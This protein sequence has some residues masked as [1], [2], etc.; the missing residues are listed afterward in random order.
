ML[1]S[2]VKLCENNLDIILAVFNAL[3]V[4]REN[5]GYGAVECK[6]KDGVVLV[7]KAVEEWH[8]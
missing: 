1:A 6:V 4:V 3:R 2:D 8:I 5:G 7:V